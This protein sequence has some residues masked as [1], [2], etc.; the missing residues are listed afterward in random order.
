MDKGSIYAGFSEF[1]VILSQVSRPK[2]AL[3][4]GSVASQ[5]D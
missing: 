4:T 3:F 1:L 5:Y 2:P